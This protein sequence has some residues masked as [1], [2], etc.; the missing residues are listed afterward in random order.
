MPLV[1]LHTIIY[2]SRHTFLWQAPHKLFRDMWPGSLLTDWLVSLLYQLLNTFHDIT[3]IFTS[4]IMKN[5]Q[6]KYSHFFIYNINASFEMH[7]RKKLS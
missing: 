2:I 6:K 3:P 4:K 5:E 7:T 1:T